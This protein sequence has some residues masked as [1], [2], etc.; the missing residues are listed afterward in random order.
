MSTLA[1]RITFDEMLRIDDGKLYE[2]VNG[3]LVEKPMAHLALWVASRIC[4]HLMQQ[5]DDLGVGWS[6]TETP[7]NCF[8]W[9]RY[10]GRRPDVVYFRRDAL[11]EGVPTDAPITVTPELVVEVVSPNDNMTEFESKLE[12]Y[13]AAKVKV[14][15]VV[16][17][18]TRTVQVLRLD[19]TGIRLR[20]EHFI[21]NEPALPGFRARIDSFFPPRTKP[22]PRAMPAQ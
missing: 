3:D 19:G 6:S 14:I 16:S 8:P 4:A 18:E 20:G 9:D 2:L 17:P 12:D 1:S 22:D 21:E 10:H 5:L 13:L 11:P 15:W 7:I